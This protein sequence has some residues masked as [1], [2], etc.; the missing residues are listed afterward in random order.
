MQENSELHFRRA[1]QFQ[2]AIAVGATV[3]TL[4]LW[5]VVVTSFMVLF[6]LPA[7]NADNA[8]LFLDRRF[9]THFFQPGAGGDALFGG[10]AAL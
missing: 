5:A 3:V 1:R 6:A 10:H 4:A 2:I 9:G 7:L 8:M